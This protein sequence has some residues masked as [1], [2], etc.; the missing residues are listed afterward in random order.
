M[1]STAA[2]AFVYCCRCCHVRSDRSR[3]TFAKDIFECSR[4]TCKGPSLVSSNDT[5][6][7]RRRLA[8]ET[9]HPDDLACWRQEAFE[10]ASLTTK[11]T[12]SDSD[13]ILCTEGAGGPLCG[14]CV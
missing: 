12:C 9:V 13:A 11:G 7:A 1:L 2:M 10:N 8:I 5:A 6:S 3:Y 14:T 4:S